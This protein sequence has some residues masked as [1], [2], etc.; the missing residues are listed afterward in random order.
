M[1]LLIPPLAARPRM[2]ELISIKMKDGSGKSLRIIDWIT[3]FSK[4]KCNAFAH[5]LLRNPVVVRALR[6]DHEYDDDFVPAVLDDWLSISDESASEAVPCT[7]ETLAVCVEEAGL[8]ETLSKAIR[9]NCPQ[10]VLHEVV[11]DIFV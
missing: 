9:D 6:K 4:A 11:T 2:D 5:K 1:I 8:D 3:S 10:G 7:W